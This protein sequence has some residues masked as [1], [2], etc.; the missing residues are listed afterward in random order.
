MGMD[1][2]LISGCLAIGTLVGWL[3][4]VVGGHGETQ[5][6]LEAQERKTHALLAH[7]HRSQVDRLE[8]M[9]LIMGALRE[10]EKTEWFWSAWLRLRER[11]RRTN[12]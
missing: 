6:K 9:D 5:R 8:E 7:I 11:S 3:I 1:W 2:A 10:P 12:A 4:G